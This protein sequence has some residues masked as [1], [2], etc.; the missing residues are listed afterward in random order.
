MKFN[1]DMKK[2]TIPIDPSEVFR[3]VYQFM[4]VYQNF[5]QLP[6]NMKT[7]EGLLKLV[8]GRYDINYVISSYNSVFGI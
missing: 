7:V 2:N 6:N 3:L 4:N 5:P 1:K 8:C